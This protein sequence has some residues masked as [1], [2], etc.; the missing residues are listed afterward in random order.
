MGIF[1][2]YILL[3]S[4]MWMFIEGTQL[5]RMATNVFNVM[6]IK[7]TTFY[8]V[9]AYSMPLLIVGITILSASSAIGVLEVYSG[10]EM[11]YLVV[12][13]HIKEILIAL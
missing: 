5:Y 7:W 13:F 6:T 3:A 8:I 10:D 2:H 12:K 11:Y 9:L 1:L 4:F